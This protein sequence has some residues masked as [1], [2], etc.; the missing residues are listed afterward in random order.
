MRAYC[1]DHSNYVG[2]CTACQAACR[3]HAQARRVGLAAGTWETGLVSG[4]E[5]E[6]VREHVRAL[7]AVPNVTAERIQ[8]VAGV[9]HH[10][11]GDLLR[12]Q[13]QRLSR[14]VAEA[15]LGTTAAACLALVGP[16]SLVDNA[17][18]V[19]R[20]RA[21][22]VDGWTVEEI[23]SLSG[24][25]PTVVERH[26]RG[27]PGRRVTYATREAYRGL[28]EKIQSLADPR[29]SSEEVRLRAVKA[30]FLGP[31]RWADEDIDNPDAQPLPPPPDTDD[32]VEVTQMIDEALRDP[33]PGKAAAYPRPVQR[34]IARQASLRLGW[35]YTRIAELLGKGGPGGAG[36]A[37]AIE[38]LLYGRKDRPRTVRGPGRDA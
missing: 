32:W 15:F 23:G 21:L 27:R 31:E 5:L 20:L 9:A 16:G 25:H 24:F 22:A 3:R 12:G 35:P 2:G 33:R 7:L 29:G 8:I 26:R 6:A 17:G 19:R 1:Y 38:Y 4:D 30:G 18:T 28:Y 34:E 37:S 10:A 14:P 11:A 13:R 36:G